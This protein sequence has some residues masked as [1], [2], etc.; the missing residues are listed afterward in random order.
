MWIIIE[1]QYKSDFPISELEGFIVLSEDGN[2]AV[3]PD[4]DSAASFKD[5]NAIDGQII[6]LPVY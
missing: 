5:E 3:F 1:M 6:E 2:V 4:K